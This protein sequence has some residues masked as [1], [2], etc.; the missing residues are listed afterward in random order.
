MREKEDVR[1]IFSHR[2]NH[3]LDKK[4]IPV[5]GMGRQTETGK[6]FGV[7]QNAAR[8]WLQGEGMPARET[9]EIMAGALGVSYAWLV[10]LEEDL[11]LA[12]GAVEVYSASAICDPDG[13]PTGKCDWDG[14]PDSA[15]VVQ[16]AD[17][18]M[19]PEMRA[20]DLVAVDGTLDP[21]AGGYVL[22]CPVSGPATLRRVRMS[23]GVEYVP[24]D[25]FHATFAVDEITRVLTIIGLRRSII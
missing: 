8:K 15:V 24:S 16:I 3:A 14:L 11:A 5:K 4:G 1:R 19:A 22:V 23:S 6:L 25:S 17:D 20:G 13:K 21:R 12:P 18:A 10:G 2:L 9:L 7:S